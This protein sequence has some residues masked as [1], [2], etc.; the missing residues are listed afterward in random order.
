[1]VWIGLTDLPN[2][3][4]SMNKNNARFFW[5]NTVFTFRTKSCLG[6]KKQDIWPKIL[7]F[8]TQTAT[9]TKSKDLLASILVHISIKKKT[10]CED[11]QRIQNQN[12]RCKNQCGNFLAWLHA[13]NRHQTL[14]LILSKWRE[15]EK[16]KKRV[17]C[18]QYNDI[19][20]SLERKLLGA[21]GQK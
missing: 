16:A 15:T 3:F 1:M 6:P 9:Y 4:E 7:L 18:C 17:K 19:S 20:I 8:R 14:K 21:L 5:G 13:N 12:W 10:H 11:F 2:S